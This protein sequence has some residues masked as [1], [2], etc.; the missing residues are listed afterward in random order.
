MN[1]DMSLTDR[2]LGALSCVLII[3][4]GF[5]GGMNDWRILL[6]G[7]A[8][9]VCYRLAWTRGRHS[10]EAEASASAAGV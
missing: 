8:G 7:L 9:M 5:W 10:A 3:C 4:I 1:D 6:L 2:M